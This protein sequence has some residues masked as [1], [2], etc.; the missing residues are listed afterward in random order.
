M[1]DLDA[2]LAAGEA[3]VPGITPGTEK[4][5]I[6][7]GAAGVRTGL[8]LVYIHGFSATSEELRPMPDLVAQALGANLF[9]TRL[10]GHGVPG[11]EMGKATL[12]DWLDDLRQAVAIGQRIGERTVLITCSTGSTL[13][14]LA[15]AEGAD[16]DGVVMLAPNFRIKSAAARILTWPGVE[17][18]GPIVAGKERQIEVRNAAHGVFWTTRYPTAALFPMARAVRA[19]RSID[20][21][22]IKTPAMVLFDPD[23]AIIDHGQTRH[24]AA[25]WGG[26][27]AVET[28]H[29]GAEDDCY[30]HVIAGDI[31][32]PGQSV[33]LAER[34]TEWIKR[35]GETRWNNGSA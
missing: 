26:S 8:S 21:A 24:V 19:A 27:V 16:V 3:R 32:S 23:D 10:A 17:I 5:V 12:E 31:L 15:L 35:L 6:W 20:Y 22:A 4:R 25:R 2:E 11:A 33:P 29:M 30:H 28:V 14:A 1:G 13:A 34:I 9:F 18:W 7:A